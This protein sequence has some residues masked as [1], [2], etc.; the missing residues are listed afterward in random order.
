MCIIFEFRPNFCKHKG[1]KSFWL[2]VGKKYCKSSLLQY[3][4][5]ILIILLVQ[6]FFLQCFTV[7][8]K[9]HVLIPR[10]RSDLQRFSY[11]YVMMLIQ[12]IKFP[13][14]KLLKSHHLKYQIIFAITKHAGLLCKK[15]E[16]VGS[17]YYSGTFTLCLHS[18]GTLLKHH[19]VHCTDCNITVDNKKY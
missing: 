16:N 1:K 17:G 4:A 18:Y 3:I 15:T 19:N 6:F 9:A 12:V 2:H 14:Q 5:L 8:V 11:E 7:Y 13:F 10:K